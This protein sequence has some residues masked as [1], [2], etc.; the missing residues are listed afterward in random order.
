MSLLAWPVQP[1]AAL[2][3][4]RTTDTGTKGYA[5]L[6][7]AMM[8]QIVL[9][10]IEGPLRFGLL[11][12]NLDKLIFIRDA[13]LFIALGHFIAVRA[14]HNAVPAA[15]GIFFVLVAV[16]GTIGYWNLH[17]PVAQLYGLKLAVPLI[18]GYLGYSIIYKPSR[19]IVWLI[20]LLW[21]LTV[22]GAAADK[23][24]PSDMPW[25][26]ANVELGGIDVT[27]G[28]DWQSGETK[29]VAGFTRSSI[30]L[31]IVLPLMTFMLMN[32]MRSRWLRVIIAVATLAVLVWTTQKGAILGFALAMV[33]LLLSSRQTAAPLK[34]AAVFSAV[35]MVFAP[36]V[37]LFVDMPRARGV[38]SFESF[39]ERVQQ[40][41][42]AAWHWIDRYQPL[43]G[44]G[45]GGIGGAQRFYAP[46]QFNAADNLFVFMYANCGVMSLV[47]LIAIV[48][49]AIS[50]PMRDYKKD[51]IALASLVFLLAYGIVISLIEDQ[52]AALWMGATVGWLVATRRPSVPAPAAI[53]TQ[54]QLGAPREA[55]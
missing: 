9:V 11:A 12:M 21:I 39:V 3:A 28:R 14:V 43:M 36:T 8:L 6:G 20:A 47:Y 44:V 5:L 51:S 46:K 53:N 26:G 7:F 34:I 23:S 1:G 40:M 30:N 48:L 25:V 31:A 16:H 4:S 33:M 2:H 18:C 27:I 55:S 42:P 50:V 49:I 10:V 15:V 24:T 22:L 19:P 52:I 32:V 13:M 54:G 41:W 17:A 45:L 35:L 38:F 37:L 29:R